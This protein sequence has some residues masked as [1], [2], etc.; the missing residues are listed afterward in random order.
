[1]HGSQ[2]ND[3]RSFMERPLRGEQFVERKVSGG[4]LNVDAKLE[5]DGWKPPSG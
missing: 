5:L 3:A 2:S 4:S 1:M